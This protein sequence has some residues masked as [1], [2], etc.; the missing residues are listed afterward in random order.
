MK[1]NKKIKLKMTDVRYL[2]KYCFMCNKPFKV[3]FTDEEKE[4]IIEHYGTLK[5]Y[6]R[7]N[8]MCMFC[9]LKME[10]YLNRVPCKCKNCH[11]Y[12][13]LLKPHK[14]Y[15]EAKESFL[16]K[17]RIWRNYCPDCDFTLRMNPNLIFT[18]INMITKELYFIK[19]CYNFEKYHS[20]YNRY[21]EK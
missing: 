8:T 12:F 13:W 10:A 7:R 19:A 5:A 14:Q 9:T 2:K 15:S 1:L 6:P 18:K 20:N 16:E 3:H 21:V 4:M 11:K 17:K